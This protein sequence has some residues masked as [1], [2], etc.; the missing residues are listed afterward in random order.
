ML[1]GGRILNMGKLR[2]LIKGKKQELPVSKYATADDVSA[3]TSELRAEIESLNKRLEAVQREG[4]R[5][6]R[7]RQMD[8]VTSVLK[9]SVP[10]G[11]RN[12]DESIRNLDLYVGGPLAQTRLFKKKKRLF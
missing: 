4:G 2:D 6:R 12:P 11:I 5:E 3:S 8:A 7:Q 9:K 1:L 10:K